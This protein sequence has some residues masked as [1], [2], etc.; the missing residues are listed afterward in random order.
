MLRHIAVAGAASLCLMTAPGTATDKRSFTV[1]DA[2][3]VTWI[4][5]SDEAPSGVISSPD[6][7]RH[8]AVVYRGDLSNNTN[9]YRLMLY[10][11]RAGKVPSS[12]RVIAAFAS[13]SNRE[14]ITL[15]RWLDH[16]TV[17]FVA[18]EPGQKPQLRSLDV[19]S[20]KLSTLTAEED[21][22]ANYTMNRVD[23]PILLDLITPIETREANARGH[24]IEDIV[25]HNLWRADG[26]GSAYVQH[27]LRVL[28][29][30]KRLDPD[31]RDIDSIRWSAWPK[32]SIA[33]DDGHAV[34]ALKRRSY[35][36]AW[37]K[38][39]R[40]AA[41][42]DDAPLFGSEPRTEAIAESPD[43]MLQYHLVDLATGQIR[44]LI[45]APTTL[46][47]G[48]GAIAAAWSPDGKSVMLANTAT[49]DGED[50]IAE[51]AAD[52]SGTWLPGPELDAERKSTLTSIAWPARD[53]LR[54]TFGTRVEQWSRVGRAWKRTQSRALQPVIAVD[55]SRNQPP[56]LAWIGKDGRRHRFTR[57]NAALDHVDLGND[58]IIKWRDDAGKEWT[59]GLLLPP[60]RKAGE[61][62]P[63]VI[64]TH[65]TDPDGFWVD[66]PYRG[67]GYSARALASRGIAV[68]DV[69]DRLE[70]FSKPGE[71]T[72]AVG[73]Y[74][75]GVA[76]LDREG[77][78][79]TK[80]VGI[81]VWSRTGLYLLDAL[82]D[83][84]VRYAA[85]SASDA[86]IFSRQQLTEGYGIPAPG[87]MLD[88]EGLM[89]KPFWGEGVKRWVEREPLM[90][91]SEIS[92]PIRIESGAWRP[93]W[94]DVYALMRRHGRP[95][96]Y[97]SYPDGEHSLVKPW[98]RL[99]SQQGAVDWYAFWL[100]G[101]EDPDLAKQAQYSR[102]RKLRE[103]KAAA[104]TSSPC[105]MKR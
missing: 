42:S 7:T 84:R 37:W 50:G 95:V 48:V 33:P 26:Q 30:G 87:G 75:A 99:T 62:V 2:I 58:R 24:V 91:L 104:A 10:D 6:G 16:R 69:Q 64:Y 46:G 85:A 101:S 40:R 35:P 60:G 32:S 19:D 28:F 61:R 52:G 93:T 65:S 80:K 14:A 77:L 1:V 102:W 18:E 81:H 51:V 82:L 17:T 89:G 103:K 68:L 94:W 21:V 78:I 90:R 71:I 20:G 34:I 25:L 53:V 105:D 79:D 38:T 63:L 29:N 72:S 57:F 11:T 86:D 83:C 97:A 36:R 43:V 59:G 12:G 96:E 4:A 45:D 54:I 88:T 41:A 39:V 70:D 56:E 98:E 76:H 49:P 31:L 92:A 23:G 22:I 66:G 74:A 9:V 15:P 67:M 100:L 55:Q 5:S 44:P 27:R 3:N 47:L 8:L 13:S 73:R